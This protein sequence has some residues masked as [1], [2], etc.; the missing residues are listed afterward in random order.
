MLGVAVAHSVTTFLFVALYPGVSEYNWIPLF[1][2]SS[3]SA[4]SSVSSPRR[5]TPFPRRCQPS[6][7]FGA[8]F[9]FTRIP[10]VYV[11]LEHSNGRRPTVSPATL[12]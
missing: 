11:R 1:R 10:V 5:Q 12:C 8:E 3:W 2:L 9:L 6:H 7:P 4:L